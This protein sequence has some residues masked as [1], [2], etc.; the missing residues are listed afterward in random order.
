MNLYEASI[1]GIKPLLPEGFIALGQ[2]GRGRKHAL[3]PVL[4]GE[5]AYFRVGA[6]SQ[7]VVLG[8][9]PDHPGYFLVIADADGGYARGVSYKVRAV[10]NHPLPEIISEGRGAWGDAGNLGNYQIALLRMRSGEAFRLRGKY[11]DT[12]I[13]VAN[14]DGLRS[15]TQAE[16]DAALGLRAIEEGDIQWL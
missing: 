6:V 7:G 11:G 4:P 1:A 2:D 14:A 12:R 10:E 9:C 3:V 13:F 8:R 15:Y 5:G 16:W